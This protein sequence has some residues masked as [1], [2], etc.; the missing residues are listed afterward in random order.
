MQEIVE[1]YQDEMAAHI[2]RR[3]SGETWSFAP[4]DGAEAMLALRSVGLEF[5]LTEIYEFAL[6]AETD[7]SAIES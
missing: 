7:G 1:I 6:P 4:I 3:E 5:P 2:Y